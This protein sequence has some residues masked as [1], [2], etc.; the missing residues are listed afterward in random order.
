MLEEKHRRIKWQAMSPD[1]RTELAQDRTNLAEDR[2][3]LAHERSFEGWVRTG[4]AAV[5]VGLGFNALF[6]AAVATWVP[7]AI[8]TI[9]LAIAIFIFLSAERRARAITNRLETHKVAALRS[10]RI[11]LLAWILA[12]T[13]G[14]LI[15][16]IWCLRIDF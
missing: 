8:A 1:D 16:A 10:V 14:A 7:K 9:F 11:R 5:G 6:K 2:T 4:L 3:V 15:V 12:A 13:T